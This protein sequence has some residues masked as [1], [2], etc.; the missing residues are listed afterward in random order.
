M[1]FFK[2]KECRFL[3]ESYPC[4]VCRIMKKEGT[5]NFLRTEKRVKEVAK[6]IAGTAIRLDE[7]LKGRK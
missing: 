7:V 6:D 3:I 1:S 4:P 5:K 2:C